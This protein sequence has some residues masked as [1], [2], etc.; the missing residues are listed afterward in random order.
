MTQKHRQHSTQAPASSRQSTQAP[1]SAQQSTPALPAQQP[2]RA[3]R[4]PEMMRPLL[5]APLLTT[6]ATRRL[7][8]V[9]LLIVLSVD[10]FMAAAL[11]TSGGN[12]YREAT[13]M[14]VASF[15]MAM[16]GCVFGGAV[17]AQW[18]RFVRPLVAS[19]SLAAAAAM[20]LS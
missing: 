4:Y 10:N 9:V 13:T 7:G 15:L 1:A 17:S 20:T 3:S 5:G 8:L 19:A 2:T 16:V 18:P 12:Y 14:A 11:E 6:L